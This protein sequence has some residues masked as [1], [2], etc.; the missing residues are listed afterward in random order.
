V[1]FTLANFVAVKPLIGTVAVIA[2]AGTWAS[3]QQIER[4]LFF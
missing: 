2:M 3:Q 1:A 4:I